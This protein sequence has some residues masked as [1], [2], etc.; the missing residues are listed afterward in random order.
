MP[1]SALVDDGAA[2]SSPSSGAAGGM[3]SPAAITPPHKLK[4]AKAKLSPLAQRSDAQQLHQQ[5]QHQLSPPQPKLRQHRGHQS[6]SPAVLDTT[7]QQEEVQE[8]AEGTPAQLHRRGSNKR[9]TVSEGG[10]A[11]AAVSADLTPLLPQLLT[12]PSHRMNAL[13]PSSPC[14]RGGCESGAR[15]SKGTWMP[16]AIFIFLSHVL[17]AVYALLWLRQWLLGNNS[18]RSSSWGPLPSSAPSTALV[19]ATA[20]SAWLNL[21]GVTAGY[22]RLWSHASYKATDGLKIFLAIIGLMSFQGSGLNQTQKTRKGA[23]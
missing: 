1:I 21:L 12:S 20:L 6:S 4:L 3:L 19:C 18:I 16:A 15:E 7:L 17:V 8:H 13:S 23:V 5:Q 10:A 11:L 22:H 9:R 2:A 14:G